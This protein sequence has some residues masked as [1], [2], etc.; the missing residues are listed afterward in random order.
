M[1]RILDLVKSMIEDKGTG[2]AGTLPTGKIA[3]MACLNIAS[4]FM[5]LSQDFEKYKT[6]TDKK[7][8]KIN[9]KLESVLLREK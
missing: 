8:L 6:E 4:K 2:M 9:K 7:I 5:K 3:V 1:E